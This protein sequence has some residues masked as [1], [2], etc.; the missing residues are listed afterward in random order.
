MYREITSNL[1]EW[2][3]NPRKKP[4][5]LTGVRQCGK[6]YIIREFAEK[7]F[8]NLVHIN[9]EE[10]ENL[11]AIFEYDFD[12]DRILKEIERAVSQQI[13]PGKT[14]LFLD[15]IQQCPRA[16]TSLKY[17]CENMRELHIVC[18]GSLLGV[19]L[20]R[21]KISFPVGKVNRMTLYPMSFK[22][23]VIANG[24]SDLIDIFS[25]WNDDRPIPE[26]YSAPMNQ[27]LKEYYIVG[28]MPEA[29]QT[30]I[31][32]NNYKEVENVQKEILNGYAD[33]FSKHVPIS[34]LPKVR[35]IWDSVHVQLAKE[36][37]KF[38]FSHVKNGKRSADLEDALQWLRDAGLVTQLFLVDKPEIPLSGFADKTYFKVYMSDIGLLRVRSGITPETILNDGELYRRYKGAFA[39]NYVLNE[40]ICNGIDP[41]FW[42]SGNIAEVDFIYERQGKLTPVEVKAADN[43]R[44]KSYT[45]FCKKYSPEKGYKLSQKNLALN[46]C[47]QTETYSLPLYL[48]WK[49]PC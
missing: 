1:Q 39:E 29:V 27:L 43:T 7:N 17:F 31:D 19:S 36:N 11:S 15:E 3:E 14:I 30:W 45:Q 35:W 8:D 33:D 18:A 21:D 22:E 40:L 49:L 47:E 16:I 26:L 6:T 23:F 42:R 5:L 9:F 12:V 46:M 37:N 48:A 4:L 10:S 25:A 24:R 41:Y 32:T 38:V 2:K 34:D 28:G 44:A 13:I 20:K